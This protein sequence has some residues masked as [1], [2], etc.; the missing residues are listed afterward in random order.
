MNMSFHLELTI[1]SSVMK[2]SVVVFESECVDKDEV[3]VT[4][5]F[6]SWSCL[7]LPAAST[8]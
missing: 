1:V 5:E 4:G 2:F 8:I 7:V 6:F 3:S